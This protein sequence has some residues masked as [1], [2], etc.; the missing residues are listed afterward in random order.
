MRS[1]IEAVKSV[2]DFSSLSMGDITPGYLTPEE[3]THLAK[4]A[5]ALWLHSGDPRDPHAELTSGMCSNG[6]V[7]VLRL[8]RFT[9]ICEMAT[10]ALVENVIQNHPAFASCGGLDWVVGSDH[11]GATLSFSA[12]TWWG[13]QHDFT[14]KGPNKT[15][16]WD[17]FKIRPDEVVLQIEELV[18]TTGTLQAV[19][20]GI[21]AAHPDYPIRFAP[22][23][24]TLV[25]IGRRHTS[26]KVC[27]F[28]ILCTMTL[29][30]GSQAS[31]RCVPPAP[32]GCGPSRTGAS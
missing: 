20:D 25:R 23:V 1:E 11:A 27:R 8:L 22:L 29:R 28:C 12:A 16:V 26:S 4:M 24:A 3:F 10:E 32:S 13:A 21:R 14:S 9:N 30:S 2:A 18:T 19:R 31:V 15:Q 17:R 7:D 5:D 6:F